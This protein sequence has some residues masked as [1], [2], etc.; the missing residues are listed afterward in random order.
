MLTRSVA[1]FLF[2]LRRR[3]QMQQEA[4]E[5][6][7]AGRRRR[8]LHRQRL[9]AIV[10]AAA[11]ADGGCYGRRTVERTEGGWPCSTLQGYL[12]GD[13]VTYK[14]KFRM[15]RA[16]V[17]FI[18]E[19]LEAGG[20]CCTNRCRDKAKRVTSIF[21]VGVVLYYM[22]HCKGDANT[23]GDVA[24]LGRSTVEQ[25]IVEFCAGVV[26]CLKP[27]FMP[28]TP[29]SAEWLQRVRGEFAARRG[30]ANV[31]MACDGT[32]CPFHGPE[33]DYRNY[34]GWTSILLVAFVTSF[35]TFVDGDV[36]QPGRAGDNTVLA[37]SWLMEQI[38]ADPV[39]WLGV[40]GVIAADGG[41]S[42][43]GAHMLNPIPNAT[44]PEDIYYNFCHSSTR[45]FVEETF[46][47]WKNRF[48][49]LLYEC[50][51][52]DQMYNNLVYA[53]LIL[54]NL[55]TIRKD[56]AV[57]FTTGADEEWQ[58]FFE[59]NKRTQCPECARR[60]A[61]HCPHV[62]NNRRASAVTGGDAHTKRE[63]IK[64]KLW[65]DMVARD[66]YNAILAEIHERQRE[67]SAV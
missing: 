21:K 16:N 10:V 2:Y 51:L 57:N 50:D 36:G 59:R 33:K 13:E 63:A 22:A 49:F 6:V 56:D 46:G 35:Y 28:S 64:A 60:D 67:R 25:Y 52:S 23:A 44:A 47:R 40:D 19:T 39:A 15:S 38:S 1:A 48:R 9:A 5:Q 42:D 29:P 26:A 54:H 43:G 58:A 65:A 55:C 34:K 31:A 62:W 27:I 24:S 30:I 18:S 11:A 20:F 12:N 17:E 8:Q 32:H 66:D 61:L 7:A 3:Q 14:L 41:A 53:S 45:F 4:A 37:D